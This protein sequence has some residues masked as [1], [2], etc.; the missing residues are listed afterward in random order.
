MADIQTLNKPE[1]SPS[2]SQSPSASPSP[3]PEQE[4]DTRTS[5][6]KANPVVTGLT[7]I[8]SEIK[9]AGIS[10]LVVGIVIMGQVFII[11]QFVLPAV[12]ITKETYQEYKNAINEFNDKRYNMLEERIKELEI[13]NKEFRKAQIQ[14][15]NN[16][17]E[18]T[19]SAR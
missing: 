3:S 14:A 10:G 2:S 19:N 9:K 4:D 16:E 18:T 11:Y 1:I 13:E 15:Q 17:K 6:K 7:N 5:E 12:Q 8:H